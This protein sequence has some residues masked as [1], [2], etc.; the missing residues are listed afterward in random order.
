M[1]LFTIEVQS[2]SLQATSIKTMG[3]F[4]PSGVGTFLTVLYRTGERPQFTRLQPSYHQLP[5][6]QTAPLTTTLNI[7]SDIQAQ[8][9]T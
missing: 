4:R 2:I 7:Q 9:P 3:T 5:N 1:P 6:G 8:Q